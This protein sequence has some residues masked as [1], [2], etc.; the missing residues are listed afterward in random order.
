MKSASVHTTRLAEINAIDVQ[1][2][3][4]QYSKVQYSRIRIFHASNF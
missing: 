3:T 2:S 1:Y 4:V